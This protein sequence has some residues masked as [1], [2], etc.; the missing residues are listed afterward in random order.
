MPAN[1]RRRPTRRAPSRLIFSVAHD[2]SRGGRERPCVYARCLLSRFKH[3]PI[4]GQGPNSVKRVLAELSTQCPCRCPFH[5]VHEASGRRIPIR[6][7][8]PRP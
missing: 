6:R 5:H 4:W 2:E 7:K 1:N 8:K 3:G